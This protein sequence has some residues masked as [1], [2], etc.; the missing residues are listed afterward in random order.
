[1]GA[2]FKHNGPAE[3]VRSKYERS[4]ELAKQAALEAGTCAPFTL[5]VRLGPITVLITKSKTRRA[6]NGN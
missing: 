3:I 6:S 5:R 4:I 1:M 2:A